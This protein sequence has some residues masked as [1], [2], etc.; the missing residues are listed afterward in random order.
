MLAVFEYIYPIKKHYSTMRKFLRTALMLAAL[1]G[2]TSC[3]NHKLPKFEILAFDTIVGNQSVGC[4]VKYRFITIANAAKSEVLTGIER[5]N[6][7]Y[8]Y[9][10][11]SYDGPTEEAARE[12]LDWIKNEMAEQE[13]IRREMQLE[14]T[15]G[16]RTVHIESESNVTDSLLNY[17]IY[18]ATYLGGAHGMEVSEYHTYSLKDGFELRAKDLFRAEKMDELAQAVYKKICDKYVTEETSL[19][20]AGFF[21]EPIS[22]TDNFKLTPEG[23]TFHYNP[24]EIGCYALGSVVVEFTWEELTP[25]RK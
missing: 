16:E 12:S 22:V 4:D 10:F 13:R 17:A 20:D 2:A 3:S 9:G 23:V 18:R 1:A 11:D 5:S 8:F 19:S 15:D 25:Y 6:I 21:N 14:P 24:Y 7:E